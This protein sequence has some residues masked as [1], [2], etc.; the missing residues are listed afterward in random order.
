VAYLVG[1][2]GIVG[3]GLGSYFGLQAFSKWSAATSDCGSACAPGSKGQ[4]EHDQAQTDATV[5]TVAFVAGGVAVAAGVL[6]FFT[7]PAPPGDSAHRLQVAPMAERSGGGIL[8][9]GRW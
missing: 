1:G 4:N 2:A 9:L 8:V 3:L 7:A 5:S 6:L